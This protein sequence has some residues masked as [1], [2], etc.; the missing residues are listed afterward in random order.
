MTRGG[1][2]HVYIKARHPLPPPR[3]INKFDSS[4][5]VFVG[6]AQQQQIKSHFLDIRTT[7]LIISMFVLRC[8][9]TTILVLLFSSLRTDAKPL[10]KRTISEVQLMHNVQ[11]HKQVGNR[12]EWLQGRLN[13]IIVTSAD[14]QHGQPKIYSKK[15]F[16]WEY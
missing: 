3:L 14:P 2:V 5:H 7:L 9:E 10:R 12:Q 1:L 13:D 11:E 16:L 15:T 4:V 6:R 8:F